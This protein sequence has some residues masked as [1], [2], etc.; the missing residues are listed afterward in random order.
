[1]ENLLLLDTLRGP[2]STGMFTVM[3]DKSLCMTKIG[4]HPLHLYMTTAWTKHRNKAIQH[5]KIIVGHNRKAT[6]GAI[7]SENSHPFHEENI[8]LVHNGMVRGGH[9]KMAETEVDSHAVCHAFNEKGAEEVLKTLDAAFAFV[10]WDISKQKL[11]AVRNDE[12]PL[13]IT[14]TEDLFILASEAWMPAVLCGRANPVKKIVDQIV[15]EPGDLYEFG[16]DGKYSVKKIELRKESPAVVHYLTH[17]PG[18]GWDNRDH[19]RS[20][21][22]RGPAWTKENDVLDDDVDDV[23]PLNR[24]V[25]RNAIDRTMAEQT[26]CGT[27]FATH[28]DFDKGDVIQCRICASKVSP[29]G[30]KT[31]VTGTCTEPGKP[32][33]D[34]VGIV[35]GKPSDTKIQALFQTPLLATVTGIANSTCGPS[36]WVAD[37]GIAPLLETHMG[38]VTQKDWDY[39]KE[40]VRCCHCANMIHEEDR[41]FTSVKQRATS[42]F[43]VTC[44]DCVETRLPNGEIKDAFNQRRLDAIQDGEPVGK[45]PTG[46]SVEPPKTESGATL[47]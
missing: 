32:Q 2:D 17:S 20:R 14:V 30:D 10:W 35:D 11:F 1:M 8:V 34:I 25:I 3:E 4:S 46:K 15:I 43:R 16:L 22:R 33:I 28:A 24:S 23:I 6:T 27:P 44:A 29:G 45:E 5:G 31:T 42:E 19:S 37:I 9:K 18:A 7:N 41:P 26:T 13:T 47:H 40:H 36:L 12:R 21:S 39:I 38:D